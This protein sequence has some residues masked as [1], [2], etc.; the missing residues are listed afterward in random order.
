MRPLAEHE[1][2]R[3]VVIGRIDRWRDLEN[4]GSA[5]CLTTCTI[6][7]FDDWEVTVDHLW[8]HVNEKID[9][10]HKRDRHVRRLDRIYYPGDVILYR[11]ADGSQDY[12]VQLNPRYIGLTELIPHFN[13]AAAPQK[14]IR[15]TMTHEL[16]LEVIRDGRVFNDVPGINRDEFSRI[17]QHYARTLELNISSRCVGNPVSADP[18][19]FKAPPRQ[20]SRGFR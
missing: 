1:G 2:K 20:K 9:P 14:T 16:Q 15:W 4:G 7:G 11:R 12:A 13:K 3:C 5:L 17:M 8:V 19:K 18:I 10:S 6:T